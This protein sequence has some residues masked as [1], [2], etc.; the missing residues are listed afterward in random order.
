MDLLKRPFRLNGTTEELA[1]W[2][3]T[4]LLPPRDALSIL[5]DSYASLS[6]PTGI[7]WGAEDTATPLSQGQELES[8]IPGATLTV[9]PGLGHIPQIEDPA[10]F[11]KALLDTLGQF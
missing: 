8:L 11:Q 10:A 3:P 4:L 1:Q 7:I 2:L 9:L 5:P 6:L